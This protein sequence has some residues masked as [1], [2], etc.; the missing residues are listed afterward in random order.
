MKA[1]TNGLASFRILARCFAFTHQQGKFGTHRDL[2]FWPKTLCFSCINH[3]W[4][5]GPIETSISRAN[6]AVLSVKKHRWDLGPIETCNSNPKVAVLYAK[7]TD[8]RWD[9]WRLVILMLITLFCIHKTTGEVW[10]SWRL[11]ILVLKSL[12]CMQKPQM[13]AGSH[14]D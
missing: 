12:F 9:P 1:G 2:Y 11:V 4:G 14:R 5:L 3:R 8:E 10:D 6:H 13:R 7:T